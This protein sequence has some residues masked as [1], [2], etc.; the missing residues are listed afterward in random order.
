MILWIWGGG[1]MQRSF[2]EVDGFR[3]QRK[4]TRREVFLAEMARVVPWRRL[5]A[6]IEPHYPKAGTTHGLV[7]TMEA[8]TGKVSDYS[9]S[10]VLL[11]GDEVTAHGDRGYADRSREPA[12]LV[13]CGNQHHPKAQDIGQAVHDAFR[14]PRIGDTGGQAIGNTQ[15]AFD[16]T[17]RKHT[18]I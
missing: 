14:C 17:Q 6:Q 8:T 11:H 13:A 9:M 4:V 12:V 10:E 16:L 18:A 5:E 3:K 7:H 15:A 2:A 1:W